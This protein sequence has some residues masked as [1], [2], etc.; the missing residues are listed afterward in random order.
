MFPANIASKWLFTGVDIFVFSRVGANC[1]R[2]IA[3]L[4]F[5]PRDSIV[6]PQMVH[7]LN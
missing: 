1:E 2:L 5:M 7:E 6:R 4:A 3:E